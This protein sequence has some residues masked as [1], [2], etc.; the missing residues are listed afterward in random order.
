MQE[1]RFIS[2]D[3]L[4]FHEE[5]GRRVDAEVTLY[6]ALGTDLSNLKPTALDLTHEHAKEL[7]AVL[8]RYFTAGHEPGDVVTPGTVPGKKDV[9]NDPDTRRYNERMRAWADTTEEF[10]APKGYH[11]L[12]RGGFYHSRPLM[13]AYRAYLRAQVEGAVLS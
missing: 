2:S 13:A 5:D 10:A 3:D 9:A 7:R 6:L 8:A 4:C 1:L 11:A 12:P